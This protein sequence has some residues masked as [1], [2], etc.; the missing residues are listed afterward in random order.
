LIY[1]LVK[2]HIKWYRQLTNRI[3]G[4]RITPTMESYSEEHQQKLDITVQE[5]ALQTL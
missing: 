4:N 5:I 3:L 2:I 1:V